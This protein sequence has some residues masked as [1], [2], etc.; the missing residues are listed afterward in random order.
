MSV[1]LSRQLFHNIINKLVFLTF[2]NKKALRLIVEDVPD[3]VLK[4][5][6]PH[7]ITVQVLA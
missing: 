1:A 4:V 3:E 6:A 2:N 5:V 7:E